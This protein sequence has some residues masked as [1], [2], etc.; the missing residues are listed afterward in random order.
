MPG[1]GIPPGGHG[2]AG[3]SEVNTTRKEARASARAGFRPMELHMVWNPAT[4]VWVPEGNLPEGLKYEDDEELIP[5]EGGGEEEMFDVQE[6]ME[7]QLLLACRMIRGMEME[8]DHLKGTIA[9]KDRLLEMRNRTINQFLGQVREAEGQLREA[10]DEVSAW[11]SWWNR[12]EWDGSQWRRQEGEWNTNEFHTP[13]ETGERHGDGGRRDRTRSPHPPPYPPRPRTPDRRRTP[14]GTEVPGGTP[15]VS[16]KGGGALR[17]EGGGGYARGEEP[18]EGGL[19]TWEKDFET[20]GLKMVPAIR[21]RDEW[22][23]TWERSEELERQVPVPPPGLDVKAIVAPE[24][25][26]ENV[27]E[28]KGVMDS[29]PEDVKAMLAAGQLREEAIRAAEL[30]KLPEL[31]A[32]EAGPLAAGD[33][34]AEIRPIMMDLSA[35]AALWWEHRGGWICGQW[36]G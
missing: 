35:S 24:Q 25:V 32:K 17:L 36:R 7:K 19:Y 8:R 16:G 23:L 2:G 10:Q 5:G 31:G 9:E 11:R 27:A 4:K 15:P 34:L 29:W 30:P 28:T 21:S 3:S 1:E 18:R 13:M 12:W 26:H 6:A 33:W 14:G 20:G 22:A